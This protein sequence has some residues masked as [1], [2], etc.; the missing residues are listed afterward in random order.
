MKVTNIKY[1]TRDNKFILSA[2][3]ILK[4][5]KIH[6]VYFEV[7]KKYQEFVYQDASP[8]LAAVL[9]LAMKLGENLEID[10]AV[11]KLLRTNTPKIMKKIANWGE[12]FKK[13][14]LTTKGTNQDLGKR[15]KVACF[16][17][18]G[19][20]SFYTYLKNKS[21]IKY[22]IFV[23]G[24][25][26]KAKNVELFTKIE[27]DIATIAQKERVELVEVK[28]NL[29]EIF[30]QYFDWDISHGFALE[31]VALFLRRGFKEIFFS[32][33][34]PSLNDEHHYLS[35][36]LDVLWST[37]NMYLHHY[38]CEADKI[39]KLKYLANFKLAMNNVRVCWMNKKGAYN[40]CECEKCFRNMLALYTVD[41][42][43]K[44]KSFNKSLDLNKLKSIR[45]DPSSIKYF[46][47]IAEVL[48]LKGDNSAVKLA[49]EECIKNNSQPNFYQQ[50]IR[51][52][53]DAIRYVD[54]KYN[55]HRLY[56]YLSAKGVI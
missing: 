14:A 23:H 18:G 13:I 24:F 39:A 16:F 4:R 51:N 11:S 53:R 48:I 35:P 8:L 27:K 10:G 31:A 19:V 6:E 9:G 7:D 29:R 45:V 28:T 36:D 42:L 17:S 26:I 32:C 50:L 30:D 46:T 20:D 25:D 47:T 40:C 21:H 38:G 3:M 49:L 43:D 1:S 55:Q 54:K 44:C 22:F 52:T 34:L 12:G 2:R 5:G 41:A 15:E 33:G 37:E 56:W